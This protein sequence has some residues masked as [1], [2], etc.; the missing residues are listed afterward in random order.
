MPNEKAKSMTTLRSRKIIDNHVEV[1]ELKKEI[2][3]T[4]I[5]KPLPSEGNENEI[6][7]QA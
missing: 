1:P 7:F 4:P 3:P 6:I 5:E 2:H